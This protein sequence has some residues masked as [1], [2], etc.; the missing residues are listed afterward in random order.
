MNRAIRVATIGAHHH[1]SDERRL[2]LALTLTGS[3][4]LVE[5]AGG[6]WSGSLALLADAGH[7]LT[8]T[9][10]LALAW[11]AARLSRRPADELR[12][13]GYHRLQILAAFLNGVFFIFIVGWILYEAAHRLLQP[14]PVI[15]GIMLWVAV[16][17]LVVNLLAFA[18]LH[19]R[20]GHNLNLRA[21]L[22]HVTGDLLGSVAAIVAAGVILLTGWYPIDP[23][24]SV[25]VALLI[26]VSALRVVRQSAHI[27][28]E[29]TPPD[30]DVRRI[31]EVLFAQIPAVKDVHHIH[32]WSLTPDRPMLTLHVTIDEPVNCRDVLS[33][34][35]RV[36]RDE[37]RIT[38][39][40]VQ[41]EPITCIDETLTNE[42]TA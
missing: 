29:G 32:A 9:A 27:L 25:L 4:M 8:D 26:L 41:V 7:M 11:L 10:S 2:L 3:F 22:L 40:T 20:H 33:D 39:S 42:T 31:R 24:L 36:L 12:S 15:G 16:T 14:Q 18:L 28:L 6:I 19:G 21:A 5:V 17:G 37:F 35:K 30:V 13:Y 38:H 23:L 34:V 1:S